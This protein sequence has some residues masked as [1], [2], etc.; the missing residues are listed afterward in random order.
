MSLAVQGQSIYG[1]LRG[2]VTDA[3]GAA[4]AGAKI[5]MTDEA[6]NLS[7]SI[8][9]TSNGEY[10]F[11]SVTPATYTV[12]TEAPGF[13][14]SER[15]SVVVATQQVVTID[16]ALDL[17]AVSES[18]MVTAEVPLLE[19]SNASQGQVVDH[20]KLIDLPN[21]G[22]NPF[23]MSRLA[24]TV[25]QVGNPA[26]NRMQD[27]SGSSQISINGGPVRGNNYLLDGIPITDFS[28]R[29][30][31]IPSLE[32]VEEMKVQ[33]STYDAEMGRTG[34]GVFNTY[35]KSGGN[36]YHGSLFGYM[37]E[38]GWLANTFFNNRNG[39]PIT[40]QPFRNYGGSFGGPVY[41]P[42]VYNGKNR[43][44]FW[45]G[46]EGYRDTQAASREQ[47]TPTALERMGNFSQTLNS[48]GAP[49]TIYDPLTTQADGSRT[50][51]PGNIIP[52]NRIDSVGRNIAATYMLPN[53][54]GAGRYYGD[55]N[56]AGAGP[57][58]SIADQKFGKVDQ[59][60]TSWWRASL[61]YLQYN[62]SEPGENPYP[63]ISSPDQW[64]LFRK[65]HATQVN[66]TLTPSSTWVVALR[67][68]F[69]RFPNIG[70]QK[71]QGFDLLSLGFNPAS[72][73]DV[74]SPTF[75]NVTMQTAHNLGTDNN[76][77]YI[78]H[79]KNFGVSASKYIGRHSVKFGY[80]FRRLH[81]DGL[82][83]GN[84]AGAFTFDNRFTRA[85]SNSS[86]SSSG[87]DIA[88]LLLGAPAVATGFLPTVLKEYVDYNGLYAHDDIRVTAKLTVNLGLRWERETGLR[89]ANNLLITGFDA[90]AVNPIGAA[91]GVNTPGVFRFAGVD[92]QK[93]TTGNPNL[94]KWSPRTGFAYQWNDKTVFRGGWGIFWAPNFALGSPYNSEGVTA[95][96]QPAS[97][98]DGNKTPALQLSNPFP[99][100]LDRPVGSSLGALTGVGK[101]M[102]IFDPNA[103]STRVQ[104]FSFDVQ[105]QL[106]SGWVATVG[107]SG[108]RTSNLTWST[109]NYNVD[110]LDPKYFSMG[111][112]L[113][114]A[115][116]NPF[117]GKGGTGVIGGA[118]VARNQL[119]RPYPQF[120]SVNLTNSDRNSAQYDALVVRVQKSMS[121]GFTLVSSYTLSK[122]FDMSGGGPGNNLN[123]GNSGPQDVYTLDGEWGLSYLHSPHRWV[124]ALTYELP[125][126]K[127]KSFGASL[128][129]AANLLAGG[130]SIN[131]VTT[132]QTGFPLQVYMNNNGNSALGTARQ[133][134][135]ATGV[136]PEVDA[137]VGQK[138]DNWINKA[139][140]ADAPA[141]TLGNVT[142]TLAMR[143]P[144]QSNWDLSVFK[145]VDVFEGFRAQFRAE[146]LNAMNTPLFRAPNT[147]FGN[148]S[149][150][151]I[152]SQGNFPRM[153]QLGLR[154]FF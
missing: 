153:I 110:Q 142:R 37:R 28:N 39:T 106:A 75:P 26:F 22:R 111:S 81:D 48:A 90:S 53:K 95:T 152:T 104:Q 6:T 149:F 15:R 102:T 29:A 103:S 120:A 14:R 19:V 136:S 118:T 98:N 141:F 135:N 9:S 2:I 42:K 63:T 89:E 52:S 129:Y 5:M 150:G 115:V 43:T 62:S 13:K 144:G 68:G 116:T 127:G 108:S 50:P 94:N 114:Q 76:F 4:I 36:S 124:S 16:V 113:T 96:T 71:S 91:A 100:G 82:N 17:G 93:E 74:A 123:A 44:F 85:N 137:P 7:R 148:G 101:P 92:G 69:N 24:A 78:H 59:Q 132:F 112:A 18:V 131:A 146:A 67:Y 51:F 87:A 38:T 105:R 121:N 140:F 77:N 139:A 46:F 31:I 58:P 60:I 126:G 154:L 8:L 70:T 35:L 86:S 134:P 72:V 55:N 138:I 64:Y 25:Q 130:W 20:Q 143:G 33:Y 34:G 84:S 56:L 32:S 151:R 10:N 88:D 99:N 122:N 54:T 11:A 47:Y 1:G 57:L 66:S 30:M 80:D 128:P 49:L 97:S 61:S 125:F 23:M 133:R 12:I 73:R 3:Q 40:D 79:S 21:L 109:A 45:I 107:Y 83:F 65:V 147:A 27:Q 119:L 145:T 117:F 41:I